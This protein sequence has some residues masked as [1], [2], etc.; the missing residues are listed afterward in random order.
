MKRQ[1]YIQYYSN[2]KWHYW[3]TP[4]I[5][6]GYISEKMAENSAYDFFKNHIDIKLEDVRIVYVDYIEEAS[7]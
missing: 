1:Y 4:I 3:G 6:G 7:E 5:G 2:N